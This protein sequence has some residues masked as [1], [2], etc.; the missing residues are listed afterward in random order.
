MYG[1]PVQGIN[2]GIDLPL[3]RLCVLGFDVEG[4]SEQLQIAWVCR[5]ARLKIGVQ[6]LRWGAILWEAA[7]DQFYDR[8]GG[9]VEA[10]PMATDRSLG[11]LHSLWEEGIFSF[12]QTL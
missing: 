9:A 11:N 12:P 8:D 4:T 5:E 6:H 3:V 10:C 1:S 7:K 2:Y